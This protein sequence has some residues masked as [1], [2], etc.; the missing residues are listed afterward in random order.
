MD[1][2]GSRLFQNRGNVPLGPDPSLMEHDH[3][4]I[5]G[6]FIDQ[7]CGPEHGEF[8]RGGQGM[9]VLHQGFAAGDIET[10]SGFIEQ[11]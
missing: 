7:V 2:V 9:N 3:R 4:I 1:G 10:D 8:A 11:Q 5:R 6:Y